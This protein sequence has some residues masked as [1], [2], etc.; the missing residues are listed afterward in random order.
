MGSFD[1]R[2]SWV[3]H[4]RLWLRLPLPTPLT[5]PS[6]GMRAKGL[7]L[8]GAAS[9]RSR[10]RGAASLSV[11]SDRTNESGC[12]AFLIWGEP[13]TPLGPRT[14]KGTKDSLRLVNIPFRADA[15]KECYAK[16]VSAF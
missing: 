16:T 2:C 6:G 12:Y 3:E 9:L 14:P 7:P 13:Q 10:S 15:P 4:H 1:S 5:P 11:G 8:P